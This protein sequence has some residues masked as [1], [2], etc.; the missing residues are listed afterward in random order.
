MLR[1]FYVNDVYSNLLVTPAKAA[2]AFAAYVFDQRV[3]D[4][5]VDGIGGLFASAAA[6]GRKVQTGL[7]RNYALGI[8][9]GAVGVLWYLAVRF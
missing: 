7:V 1:G 3:I 4:G 6:V 5:A 2:S 9:L 8:L